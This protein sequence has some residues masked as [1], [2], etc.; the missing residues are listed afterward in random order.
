M[1]INVTK[2]IPSKVL[3]HQEGQ[4]IAGAMHLTRVI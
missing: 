4:N 3:E 2:K 1:R